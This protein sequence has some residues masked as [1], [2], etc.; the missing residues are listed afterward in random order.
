MKRLL[1]S[2]LALLML[3]PWSAVAADKKVTLTLYMYRDVTAP[4]AGTWDTLVEAF[5]KANPNIELQAEYLF[6]DPYHTKLKAMAQSG[7]LPD[8]FFMWPDKRTGYLS[9]LEG[10]KPLA[11]DLRPWVNKVKSQ[12]VPVALSPQGPNGEIFEVPEQVTATHVM[13]V[14][15]ALLKKLGLTFPKTMAELVAQ[16]DKIRAAG[17][18]PIAMAN[19]DGWQMQSCFLSALTERAGGLD[20]YNKAI[21]GKGA[22]FADPQFVAAL[23]VIKELSDKQMFDPGINQMEYQAA[24]QQFA[25][26]K[27]VYYIDGGWKVN[28]LLQT[29]TPEQKENVTLETFPTIPGQKGKPGSTSLVAGTG[30]GMN[31]KLTG[32]K[33]EAAWKLI[34]FYAGPGGA[35]IRMDGGALPAYKVDAKKL[36]KPVDP[37]VAKL[38][39]FLAEK[40]YGWVI[41]SKMDGAGMQ[42]LHPAIQEMMLGKKTPKQ[43]ADEYETWVKANDTNRAKKK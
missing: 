28:E 36:T 2:A 11:K 34:Y 27:A 39:K 30:L 14:N 16:G 31:A 21:S 4:E 38:Q 41:D 29:L 43:V 22:S 7:Q 33:A 20:W 25:A 13:F 23:N 24:S 15:N 8:V 3:A 35:E 26:D 19:K 10:G 32:E 18:V 6:N 40:P 42:V 17:L 37:L 5:K 12:F 1:W 9:G